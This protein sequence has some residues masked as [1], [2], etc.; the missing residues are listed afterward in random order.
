[1]KTRNTDNSIVSKSVNDSDS[2]QYEYEVSD[3]TVEDL[4]Y[5]STSSSSE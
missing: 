4:E 3:K 5:S 1:M 2:D